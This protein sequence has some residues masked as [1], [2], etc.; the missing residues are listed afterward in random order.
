[1]REH[2]IQRESTIREQLKSEFDAGLS[3]AD[4]CAERLHATIAQLANAVRLFLGYPH[5][6][7]RCSNTDQYLTEGQ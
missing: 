1:M 6:Q 2:F 5:V 3:L 7:Y 4:T